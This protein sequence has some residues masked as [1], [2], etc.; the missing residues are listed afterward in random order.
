MHTRAASGKT[1]QPRSSNTQQSFY[2]GAMLYVRVRSSAFVCRSIVSIILH[3]HTDTTTSPP[4]NHYYGQHTTLPR[5]S[6]HNHIGACARFE[7]DAYVMGVC[8]RVCV[9]LYRCETCTVGFNTNVL[10][11]PYVHDMLYAITGEI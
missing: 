6:Q 9:V 11:P 2:V 4:R 7:S 10:S 1:V 5:Y 8:I 3:T